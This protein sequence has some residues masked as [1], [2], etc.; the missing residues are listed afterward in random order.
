M[1]PRK[2]AMYYTLIYIAI[3]IILSL[4][5]R[6]FFNTVLLTFIAVMIVDAVASFITRFLHVPKRIATVIALLIYFFALI[7]GLV[8]IVPNAFTQIGDFYKLITDI[9]EKRTWEQYINNEELINALNALVDFIEPSIAQLANYL[10]REAAAHI[11]GVIVVL[12]FSILGAVYVSLYAHHI[13]QV[14]PLLY[15]R[16]CRD[17]INEFL[18]ELKINMRRFIGVIALNAVI[19]G[20]AF[21]LLFRFMN[22]PYAPLIAFWAFL[23]NFIPI[24]GVIFE[25][26]PIFLFSL[27]LGLTGMFWIITFS[28]LIHLSVFIFFFEAMKGYARVNPVLMIF[29]ILITSEIFGPVG[30]FFGVPAAVFVVV[31]YKQFIKAQLESE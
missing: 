4:I 30:I 16:K 7:W 11:P 26:I 15:P 14:V 23:T 13:V 1:E 5:Y 27:S 31:F 19:V 18:S 9:I 24:V 2:V 22:L 20:I 8:M 17:G 12:F 28:I 29:S 25:F 6:N 3:F 21:A 10:L